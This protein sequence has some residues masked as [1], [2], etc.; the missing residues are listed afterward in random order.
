M[1]WPSAAQTLTAQQQLAR[2]IY[3]E[4][5]E[6]DTD[7]DTGDTGLAADAMAARLRAAGFA[8]ADV[9]V[10]R[11]MALKGGHVRVTLTD[12]SGGRLKAVAWRSAE[13][14]LGRRLLAG[15]GGL[16]V[17]GRLKPDDWQGR[18]SVELEIEE[19]ELA[20]LFTNSWRYLKFA[21][22]N[23]FYVM[24]N[25]HGLDFERIRAALAHE[26]HRAADLPGAGAE[27]RQCGVPAKCRGGAGGRVP[28]VPALPAGDHAGARRL[29]WQFGDGAPGGGADRRGGAGPGQC[30]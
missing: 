8:A 6:I 26:Y 18:Q 23:Q 30:R 22:A 25:D 2:D 17:A 10:E 28:P 13:T 3:K 27:A 24:A 15:G 14:D 20:K 19:A 5:V 21:A 12:R 7:T 1:S 16:H 29:A 9:Q 4:L 11:P